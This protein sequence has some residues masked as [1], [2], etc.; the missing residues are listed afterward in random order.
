MNLK[1]ENI[2]YQE[3]VA[4]AKA[5]LPR[6]AVMSIIHWRHEGR[7]TAKDWYSQL[8][9]KPETSAQ[10]DTIT[11]SEQANTETTA[12]AAAPIAT[13]ANTTAAP[14]T[15][16]A[17]KAPKEKSTKALVRELFANQDAAYS[18]DEIVAAT[19]KLK[20]TVTATIAHLKNPKACKP[21]DPLHLYHW[22]DGKYRLTAPPV[23]V[24]APAVA[25]PVAAPTAE[26][27][28]AIVPPVAEAVAPVADAAPSDA[29][30]Q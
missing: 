21:G 7:P 25:A 13:A 24:A 20:Q 11:M 3:Y 1:E 28:P 16:A 10:G 5:I 29:A 12:P 22:K 27:A 4:A 9:P 14:A 30:P 17:P 26:A 19:G 15:P 8:Q 23:E 18:A 6:V 2:A